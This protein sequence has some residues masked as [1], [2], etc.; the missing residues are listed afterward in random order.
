MNFPKVEKKDI[1]DQI[2]FRRVAHKIKVGDE[3]LFYPNEDSIP[4]F[5]D[6]QIMDAVK[7]LGL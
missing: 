1:P 5:F 7:A 3:F 6:M 4:P 2:C